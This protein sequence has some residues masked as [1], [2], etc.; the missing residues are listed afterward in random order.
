MKCLINRVLPDC[1]CALGFFEQNGSC[2]KCPDNCQVCSNSSTCTTCSQQYTLQNGQCVCPTPVIGQFCSDPNNLTY[3]AFA[4]ADMQSIELVFSDIIRIFGIYSDATFSSSINN[5]ILLDSSTIAFYDLSSTLNIPNKGCYIK[6]NHQNVFVMVVGQLQA[7]QQLIVPTINLSN[8]LRYSFGF[9]NN[10]QTVTTNQSRILIQLNY[11]VKSCYFESSSLLASTSQGG[12][13][14]PF[15]FTQSNIINLSC[16]VI[17]QSQGV[18]AEID[19]SS[20]LNF[21]LVTQS[22][23]VGNNVV[24]EVSC[25]NM[26]LITTKDQISVTIS[27]S[28]DKITNNQ[29][30]VQANFY[31]L[32]QQVMAVYNI[33]HQTTTYSD[34]TIQISSIPQIFTAYSQQLASDSYTLTIPPNSYDTEGFIIIKI[35]VQNADNSLVSSRYML[36]SYRSFFSFSIAQVSQSQTFPLVNLSYSAQVQDF[37]SKVTDQSK[38][39]I[40]WFCYDNQKTPQPCQQNGAPLV[41]NS[42]YLLNVQNFLLPTNSMYVF[43]AFAF[44]VQDYSAQLYAF[45]P[46]QGP[47]VQLTY[48]ISGTQ[49]SN[50]ISNQDYVTINMNYS[51]NISSY[52]GSNITYI[53]TLTDSTNL[54]KYIKSISSTII[55]CVQDYYPSLQFSS[56]QP[57]YINLAFT[58]HDQSYGLDNFVNAQPLQLQIRTPPLGCAISLGTTS[59]IIGFQDKVQI[60][61]NSCQLDE[62]S[63]PFTYQFFLYQNADQIKQEIMNPSVILRQELSLKQSET[64]ITT[65]LPPGNLY[66]MVILQGQYS[67]SANFTQSITVQDNKFS[68]SDYETFIQSTFNQ[69]QQYQQ[70]QCYQSEILSYQTIT[71]A[72]QYFEQKNSSYTPSDSIYTLKNSIIQR[73]SDATWQNLNQEAYLLSQKII[74]EI[75]Q[76]KTKVSIELSQNLKAQNEQAISN[77]LQEI[78]QADL[79]KLSSSQRTYYKQ[80]L[81]STIQ[82][83]MLNVNN[84]N[85]WS[86]SDCQNVIKQTSNALGGISQVMM[87]N[88]PQQIFNTTSSQLQAEKL[89]FS[90]LM[91]KYFNITNTASASAS[92]LS[93]NYH[94]HVQ[95]YPTQSK[96]YRNELSDINNEYQQ[97]TT[98]QEIL[99]LLQKTYPIKIPQITTDQKVQRA[100]FLTLQE[101]QI[102]SPILIQFG[103]I[104][105]QEKLKC[106]QRSTN[107]KWVSNSCKSIVQVIDNKIQI[108]CS[109]D[110]PDITSLIAD[111]DQLFN[112]QN[113]QDIFNGSGVDRLIHL[114]GWYKYAPIWTIVGL[115]IF[116]IIL[117]IVGFKLDKR[118]KH[119][120]IKKIFLVNRLGQVDSNKDSCISEKD[121]ENQSVF[122]KVKNSNKTGSPSLQGT[123]KNQF[124]KSE[125]KEYENY[126][127]N[128]KKSQFAQVKVSEDQNTPKTQNF[129]KG[130]ELDCIKDS[131]QA[132]QQQQITSNDTP[133]SQIADT[134]NMKIEYWDQVQITNSPNINHI[135]ETQQ[136]ENDALNLNKDVITNQDHTSKHQQTNLEESDDVNEIP[137]HKDCFFNKGYFEMQNKKVN[138]NNLLTKNNTNQ[139]D[140]YTNNFDTH[141]PN[142]NQCEIL[143]DDKF[144]LEGSKEQEQTNP[145][146]L[147]NENDGIQQKKEELKKSEKNISKKQRNFSEQLLI[148]QLQENDIILHIQKDE[149]QK[150][151]Q[152]NC[153]PDTLKESKIGQQTQILNSQLQQISQDNKSQEITNSNQAEKELKKY[154]EKLKLF[155]AK[156][157]LQ[158]YLLSETQINGA[159]VFHIFFQTFI[160]YDEKF[161]RV[162]RF[163]IYYN[164]MVWLLAL[165]SIFGV[166]LSV[167]QIAILSI[168]T[169]I[170]LLIVTTIITALLSKKKLKVIGLVITSLF[171]LF[172]YYS[173]LVVISG[174]EPYEANIW[175]GSYFLTIFINEYLIGLPI[176]YAMYSISKQV[177]NKVENPIILQ[178]LGTGLLIEAFK[179]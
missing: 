167:A 98:S 35:L 53:V 15:I 95:T 25:Q 159:L 141:S 101:G 118:D 77:I 54:V 121:S 139:N 36:F 63:N 172:C 37:D 19:C 132:K 103:Q 72:I 97:N 57:T 154:Q 5:C 40:K 73:L 16:Q 134:K 79:S 106:I 82:N 177:L 137:S 46:I 34:L 51:I 31:Y 105:D 174:Q 74:P 39:Y 100:R 128:N 17:S 136:N 160:V 20:K 92:Q 60:S 55:F 11:I 62:T 147:T 23:Q 116:L 145:N 49:S 170:V 125:S 33:F 18:S 149:M 22:L 175:I 163:V 131:Q 91:Q 108:S 41:L 169:T 171:L 151:Q 164:K 47:K 158:E 107:G 126:Q 68:N 96:L 87:V 146:N 24:I 21:N 168:I 102:N 38:F 173:I 66:I 8:I 129:E 143:V 179:N 133:Q 115:N 117:L 138:Q 48:V 76:S 42:G 88:E 104:S 90:T 65:I 114:D 148:Q 111:I 70:S 3:T 122:M 157:K 150:S 45:S 9:P 56:S 155:K 152:I 85:S 12:L 7:Q 144:Q 58:A 142:K 120:Y 93:L 112:N 110:N 13:T 127:T 86:P 109:C 123:P 78:S 59:Q 162:I 28:P 43:V 2:I 84:I 94:V 14:V 1:S 44:R 124:I 75:Q 81:A 178:I 32:N 135:L 67:T 27:N 71:L 119:S 50:L 99:S 156:E 6:Q 161:S 69:A 130:D 30:Q 165:N 176:C 10:V 61:V 52:K 26:F 166:N 80:I 29:P 140:T 89:D 64:S 153:S 83:F 113:I 4:G